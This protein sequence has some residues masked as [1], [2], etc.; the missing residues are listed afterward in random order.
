[1]R[2]SQAVLLSDFLF[3]VRLDSVSILQPIMELLENYPNTYLKKF[4]KNYFLDGY[5]TATS[6]RLCTH[7]QTNNINIDKN[8]SNNHNISP[9]LNLPK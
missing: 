1:M 9:K 8:R 2:A 5:D 6:L 3:I 7:S 4:V